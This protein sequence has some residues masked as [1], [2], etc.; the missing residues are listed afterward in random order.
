MHKKAL[1]V[2][3]ILLLT[4]CIPTRIAPVIKD[5]KIVE[6]K[7]FKRNLPQRQMF[8]FKDTKP[9][10]EFY[11]YI[12]TKFSLNNIDVQDDVPFHINK[13]QHFFSFYEVE[14]PNKSINLI[15]IATDIVLANSN[16]DPT[17][18]NL[19]ATR[20]GNWYIALEVY[21]DTDRDCLRTNS[22]SYEEVTLFLTELKQE[23][24]NTYNYNEV[25]FKQ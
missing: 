8:I 17:F 18:E 1:L 21:N 14:I 6:G 23:Y 12:N 4:S 2:I 20:K 5:Y 11:H 16:L 19:Y 22:P 7:K 10:Y 9:A 13:K 15:P 3:S 24:L 25:L